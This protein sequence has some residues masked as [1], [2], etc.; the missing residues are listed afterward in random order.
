MHNIYGSIIKL[1]LRSVFYNSITLTYY[2]RLSVAILTLYLITII[3]LASIR[4]YQYLLKTGIDLDIS[5]ILV[6]Y[7]YFVGLFG[8]LYFNLYALKPNLFILKDP[9]WQPANLMGDFSINNW[10]CLSDFTL[11][12]FC[13]IFPMHYPRISS[14]SMLIS[15]FNIFESLIGIALISLFIS[16][17]VQKTSK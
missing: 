1:P 16:T 13:S 5:N 17:F 7:F 10:L 15:S 4:H 3:A 11:Y 9:F 12:S 6:F 2:Y 8:G 14:N